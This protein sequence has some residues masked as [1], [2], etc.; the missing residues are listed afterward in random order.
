M[1]AH[2]LT[3]TLL[4]PRLPLQKMSTSHRLTGCLL[5]KEAERFKRNTCREDP[6]SGSGRLGIARCLQ[7]V[8]VALGHGRQGHCHVP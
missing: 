5:E 6:T 2:L 3:R 7:H 8:Q 4:F 1:R